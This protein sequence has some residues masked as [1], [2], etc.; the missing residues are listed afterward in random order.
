MAFDRKAKLVEIAALRHDPDALGLYLRTLAE[1]DPKASELA[2]VYEALLDEPD[3]YL[4]EVGL[5]ALLFAFKRQN[6]GCKARALRFLN[7]SEEDFEVRLWAATGLAECY[8]GTKDPEIMT[9]MLH[10]LSSQDVSIAL[11]NVCLKCVV[12]VW[13]LTP[14]EGF[15][16]AHRDGS[17]D[18][19]PAFKKNVAAFDEELQQIRHYLAAY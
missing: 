7:D 5:Y 13:A 9:G 12:Q 15:Q 14:L 4:K 19:E 1:E 10:L 6:E 17:H 8:R 2:G 16:R 11:R 18:D 3:W